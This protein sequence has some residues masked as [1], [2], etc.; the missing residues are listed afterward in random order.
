MEV[1]AG[2]CA[3]ARKCRPGN[4]LDGRNA[5][6]GQLRA[7]Q[8]RAYANALHGRQID[9]RQSSTITENIVTDRSYPVI[10]VLTR[11]GA[12]HNGCVGIADILVLRIAIGVPSDAVIGGTPPS[13]HIVLREINAG[14]FRGITGII[15]AA[16]VRNIGD[17]L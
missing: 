3:T 13:E 5:D 2:K 16:A 1:N 9:S 10:C 15:S 12:F 14:L 6:A 8:E 11:N 7:G 17:G 4:R